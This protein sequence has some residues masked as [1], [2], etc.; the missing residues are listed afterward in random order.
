MND[1]PDSVPVVA[2][3][4]PKLSFQQGQ[5]LDR[6]MAGESFFFTGPAGTGKSVLF[7]A[8]VKAFA[9]KSKKLEARQRVGPLPFELGITASTG[10]AAM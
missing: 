6:I 4:E 9:E 2:P 5:I 7:R 8:I 3:E 10:M 1:A